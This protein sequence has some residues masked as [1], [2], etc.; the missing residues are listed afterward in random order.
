MCFPE[1]QA[2]NTHVT[3]W[4]PI[5]TMILRSGPGSSLTHLQA[6]L[7]GGQHKTPQCSWSRQFLLSRAL[8]W[9]L[10]TFRTK[11]LRLQPWH[12]PPLGHG[13]PVWL[14]PPH[15]LHPSLHPGILTQ[16]PPPMSFFLEAFSNHPIRHPA[17]SSLLPANTRTI[18]T[19][20]HSAHY[21]QVLGP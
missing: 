4:T 13:A 21:Q 9:F 2:S 11:A 6:F 16:A 17:H 7:Q 5:P 18:T 14:G 19:L 1:N 15:P 12:A 8:Q 10:S 3:I 20:M